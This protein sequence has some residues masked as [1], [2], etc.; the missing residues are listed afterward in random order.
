MGGVGCEDSVVG[1]GLQGS[2]FTHHLLRRYRRR[3]F[4]IH[5]PIWDFW[6]RHCYYCAVVVEV[7]GSERAARSGRGYARI[8]VGDAVAWPA[9]FQ[10]ALVTAREGERGPG[11]R[12]PVEEGKGG[13]K[14]EGGD[15]R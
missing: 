14:A 9:Q 7:E 5:A 4:L 2:R 3:L 6:L 10:R 13:G 15:G 11:G 1:E 8:M 12:Q